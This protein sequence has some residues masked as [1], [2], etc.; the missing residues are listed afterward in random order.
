VILESTNC[1]EYSSVLKAFLWRLWRKRGG[2]VEKEICLSV[3]VFNAHCPKS[4]LCINPTP[5]F[6]VGPRRALV[7]KTG[8][9]HASLIRQRWEPGL[10]VSVLADPGLLAG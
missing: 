9:F 1:L 5:R 6:P 2:W 7:A 3:R 8:F 4:P 10:C